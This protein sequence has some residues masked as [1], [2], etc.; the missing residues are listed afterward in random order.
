MQNLSAYF[1]KLSLAM[2]ILLVGFTAPSLAN[3]PANDEAPIKYTVRAGDNLIT[4]GDRYFRNAQSYKIVQQINRIANPHA[5][6]VGK[7]L[8]IPRNV[9]KFRPANAK[10]ISVRGQVL[11]GTSAAALAPVSVGQSLREGSALATS[12]SSFATLQLDDGSRV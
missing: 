6:P 12:A 7:I 9:L 3:N 10:L 11:A 4:L 1:S 8:N 2:A 5:I